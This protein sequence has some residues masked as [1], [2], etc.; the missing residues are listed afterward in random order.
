MFI[1]L[2]S[3]LLLMGDNRSMP[4]LGKETR[5]SIQNEEL[6]NLEN[7]KAVKDWYKSLALFTIANAADVGSSYGQYER[8]PL[9]TNKEG[10]FGAKG[11]AIKSAITGGAALAEYLLVKKKPSLAK[12]LKI[13]NYGAAAAP[14]FA[15]GYN[16]SVRL[17]N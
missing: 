7:T 2:V 11:V 1:L 13:I 4:E 6:K 12:Y 9:L 8:N 3:F 16:T 15:A 10:K 14:A 5:P 17:R